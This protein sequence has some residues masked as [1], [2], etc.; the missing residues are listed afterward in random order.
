MTIVRCISKGVQELKYEYIS[1][2]YSEFK[3]ENEKDRPVGLNMLIQILFPTFFMIIVA[4]LFYTF[5]KDMVKNIFVV[6]ILY[7]FFRWFKIIVILNRIELYDWKME[8]R[9]FLIGVILNLWIYYNF[10]IKTDQIFLSAEE[11]REEIWISCFLFILVLI[12]DYIYNHEKI[13]SKKESLKKKEYI[14]SKY[15]K[16]KKKYDKLVKVKNIDISNLIYA[17]MIYENYNRPPI[18]REI[19]K[20][21]L[22][23][24]GHATL[25]IMQVSVTNLINNEESIKLGVN[26]ILKEIKKEKK[27]KN[28][29]ISN[30]IQ[31]YNNG[32]KYKAEVMYI[33]EIIRKE[34]GYNDQDNE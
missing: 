2:K 29:S 25:G 14:I 16:Y 18:I 12:R 17:I 21:K 4:G 11:L 30:I 19:E 8:I 7:Y 6:T 34:N 15:Y 33:Y 28:F 1:I 24:S 26:K 27:E 31:N 3:F 13:S 5:N 22:L 10:V 20:I 23:I 32:E 9:I